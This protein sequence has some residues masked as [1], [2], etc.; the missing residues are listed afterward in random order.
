MSC[1]AP[2]C[3]NS[4]NWLGH[5]FWCY[6]FLIAITVNSAEAQLIQHLGC[7]LSSALCVIF[8]ACIYFYHQFTYI[9]AFLG[10]MVTCVC[11]PS[12]PGFMFGCEH[13][14]SGGFPVSCWSTGEVCGQLIPVPTQHLTNCLSDRKNRSFVF[15]CVVVCMCLWFL[16]FLYF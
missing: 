4:E 5:R 6:L 14:L 2:N 16:P 11:V 13:W 10:F 9:V 15:V 12:M 7:C 1:S 8:T 3:A